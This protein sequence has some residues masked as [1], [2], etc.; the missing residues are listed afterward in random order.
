MKKITGLL[1]LSLILSAFNMPAFSNGLTEDSG[2][3]VTGDFNSSVMPDKVTLKTTKEIQLNNSVVI[4]ENSTIRAE[5]VNIQQARRWHKSGY[6]VCKLKTFTNETEDTIT[7]VEDEDI[8]L[9][10]RK[11]EPIDKKEAGKI[12]AEVTATTAASF[13]VPG[14]DI[15]YYFTKGAIHKKDGETRFKSGVSSA[16]DNSVFW[17]WLKGKDIDLNNKDSVT[18]KQIELNKAQQLNTQIDK[19]KDTQRKLEETKQEVINKVKI[20]K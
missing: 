18:V 16:Y 5:V 6:I 8:Y 11:F 14:I 3:R 20:N 17:F 19:R 2:I 13:V 15:V 9:I 1:L 7:N 12:A 4:P 10:V